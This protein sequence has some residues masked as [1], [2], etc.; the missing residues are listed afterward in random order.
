[1]ETEK[2]KSK[3]AESKE[4][5]FHE[6]KNGWDC[7]K[8][9]NEQVLQ[10]YNR[11]YKSFLDAAKTE[12]EA[13]DEIIR[14]IEPLGYQNLLECKSA[15]KSYFNHYGKSIAIYRDGKNGL[16]S[17]LNILV[18][19]LDSPR[20]DLKQYPIYEDTDIVFF[21]THYYGGI[22]K[23]QWLSRPLAIHGV[24]ILTDGTKKEIVIGEAESDPVFTIADLLIHLSKKAQM[25]KTVA[26]FIPGE[27]LNVIIG[28]RPLGQE[29]ED[30]RSKAA[31]LELLN[32]KFGIKEEDFLSADLEVVPAGKARDVGLDR[33]LIG[34]YGHDDRVCAYASLRA[35]LD[36]ETLD[37]PALVLL[38]DKEEIGSEGATGSNT[39]FLEMVLGE[40][41]AKSGNDQYTKLRR[42]LTKASC[43]SADVNAA[44]HPDWAEVHDKRNAGYLGGG[45][46]I[47]KFTG[48]GGKGGSNEA[49]AEFVAV[50]R[51][52]FTDSDIVWHMA[53]LGKIDEGGGGTIA[54]FMSYYGMNVIDAGVP[55]LDMHSPF[56]IVS[57]IDTWNMYQGFKAF[58]EK[59]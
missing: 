24:V 56:E 32:E 47:S 25:G 10:E 7:L 15:D 43:L 52:I 45:L 49:N 4:R 34:G 33:A 51:K 37:K 27:K 11:Q 35:I 8:P 9:E 20:L 54:K 55:V 40:I 5:L 53:E 41:L 14:Q 22:K 50:L 21:K 29:K 44:V 46:V 18:A 59:A 48:S 26:E 23:Y 16:E 19:H 13:V 38:M 42:L 3:V 39:W 2:A 28:A 36:A 17:G 6:R 30:Q 31:I 58:L 1:M 57:K 12:R